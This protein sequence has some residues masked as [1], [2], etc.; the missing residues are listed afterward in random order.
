LL[1]APQLLSPSPTRLAVVARSSFDTQ[2]FAEHELPLEQDPQLTAVRAAPQLSVP[3]FA[4]HVAPRRA[5]SSA[6]LSGTHTHTPLSQRWRL[7]H[8][9]SVEA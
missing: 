2:T 8:A 6:S 1:L 7:A 9:W 5:Q 3:L 4:P